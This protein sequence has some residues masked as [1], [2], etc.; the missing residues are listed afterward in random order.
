MHFVKDGPDVPDRLVQM[1]EDGLVV[2]FCG[3][4]IS[5]PAGLP[6]FGGLVNGLFEALGEGPN[7][8]EQA[9]ITDS[10]F[11]AAIELLERRIKN[12]ALVREKV[13]AILTPKDLTKP[14]AIAT[15]RALLTLAKARDGQTRLVT[16]NFDRI[17]CAVEK[18]LQSYAAPLLPIPK[19][20]RWNGLVYLHGL[21]PE[22][23]DASALNNLVV[24]SGDFGLAYLTERWASRFVAELFRGYTVCFVGYSIG[25]PVLRYMLD[26]LSADRLMGEST[27]DVFAFGSFQ[28]EHK[29]EEEQNWSAKGVTPVLYDEV[30]AHAL[31]HKMLQE[32]SEVYRDGRTGKRA[33]ITYEAKAIRSPIQGD[34]QISRVL[35][36]ITDPSGQPAKAFAELDPAPP[37]EWLAVFAQPRYTKAD[38]PKFGIVPSAS[39]GDPKAFGL[40]NHPASYELAPWTALAGL[41]NTTR[42]AAQ[43]DTVM[44]HVACWLVRHLDKP[45]VL[46]WV[47]ANGSSLHPTFCDLISK[48]LK[49]GDLPRPLVTIWRIIS[50][51]LVTE[52]R[53]YFNSYD[54]NERFKKLGWSA[55]L[56][57]ELRDMLRPRVRFREPFHWPV[58]DEAK[59]SVP[60][61]KR[62]PRIKDYADWDIT[63]AAGEH[64]RHRLDAMKKLPGWP[65]A[66]MDC[67]SEFTNLLRDT[68]DLMA[69]LEGASAQN[70][71]SYIH[72]PSIGDHSQNRDFHGWTILVELCRDT[73]LLSAGHSPRHA[74]TE[75]ERWKLI[76]YPVFRRLVFYAVVN[77]PLIPTDEAL[78][79]LLEDEAWWLWSVA[80]RRESFLLL[81]W[82]ASRLNEDQRAQLCGA[83]LAGPPHRMYRVDIGEAAWNDLVDHGVWL[84]LEKLR[85]SGA[86]LTPE[87]EDRR[88]AI[89]AAHSEWQVRPDERDE[90]PTWMESGWGGGGWRQRTVLPREKRQLADALSARPSERVWHED[91]WQEICRT[92]PEKAIEALSLLASENSWPIEVWRDALQVFS[93]EKL[94]ERSWDWLEP[95]LLQIPPE[96]VR[97][98]QHAVS[99]WLQTVVKIVP[100]TSGDAWLRLIDRILDCVATE[101]ADSQDDPV[102]RAINH[103][104]G[105]IAEAL[106]RWWYRTEP[107]ANTGVAEPIKSR[108]NR[109]TDS[110]QSSFAYGLVILAQRLSSLFLVDPNW[111]AQ[112]LLPYFDWQ[113]GGNETRAVW[114]GYLGSPRIP[115]GLLDSFKDSFL[116]SA[117][118]YNDLGEYGRQYALLLTVAALEFRQHFTNN[119]LRIAFNALPV[120]GLAEA[121]RVLAEALAHADERREEYWTHRVKPLISDVWPKSADR[122]SGYESAAFAEVCVNA[123]ERFQEALEVIQPFLRRS[124]RFYVPVMKLAEL[125]LANTYPLEALQL[126]GAIVDEGEQWPP[127]ELQ[128][129]LEQI[130]TADNSLRSRP[131]YRRLQEYLQRLGQL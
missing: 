19:R 70:D 38:L 35:W 52:S 112:K 130:G 75:L 51:G 23:D 17:F 107:K 83:I 66:A 60:T 18:K 25:D 89:S 14:E 76:K 47:L 43:I 9:A 97:E 39:S 16:T 109:F 124:T 104:V 12:Q 113:A 98:L 36:A 54:W 46:R 61:E 110:T 21:L 24:S 79:L 96:V 95:I 128:T 32:W 34:G 11:D 63:L 81:A 127:E 82:L 56:R 77:S 65:Q 64:P 48:R 111:T 10:R 20:S 103:P 7:S 120:E 123:G 40:L 1:H 50:A 68:M 117:V 88:L 92:D 55:S 15:H 126:L 3:A 84:R 72:R 85:G 102:S 101:D 93:E 118:H 94:I 67:L 114:Q 62:E 53:D 90:F 44:L 87:A 119:E 22:D 116:A 45:E 131:E 74:R 49:A 121:A 59:E 27:Q 28:G 71:L 5:Y 41:A 33:I 4:G 8:A 58:Q 100:E 115:E 108:L 73:W 91:D 105:Q 6:G 99:W 129:C 42:G 106:I 57:E 125:N 86:T 80:T 31:L 26:A 37:I 13:C 30:N 29:A 78:T 69:E 122:R 2:F